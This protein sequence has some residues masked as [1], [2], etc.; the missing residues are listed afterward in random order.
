MVGTWGAM[1]RGD[2]KLI[3]VFISQGL[4]FTGE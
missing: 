2:K 4:L 3:R 1:G